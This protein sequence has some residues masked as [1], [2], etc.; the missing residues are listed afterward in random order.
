MLI[1]IVVAIVVVSVIP[2]VIKVGLLDGC[3]IVGA[4]LVGREREID[5][6]GRG[7]N[8]NC[9][10]LGVVI[11]VGVIVIVVERDGNYWDWQ[12]LKLLLLRL[13]ELRLLKLELLWLLKL[14]LRL[15]DELLLELPE[16]FV[17]ALW[18]RDMLLDI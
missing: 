6:Q 1:R 11:V 3:V 14:L 16:V 13:F 2:V 8:G 9:L 5:W 7:S 17:R 12:E 4:I 10:E 15:F 18:M